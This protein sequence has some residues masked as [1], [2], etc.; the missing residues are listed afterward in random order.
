MSKRI[1]L[2]DNVPYVYAVTQNL[3]RQMNKLEQAIGVLPEF[4][5]ITPVE[6][7]IQTAS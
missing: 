6:D 3:N 2:R 5:V 4:G 7:R 1:P